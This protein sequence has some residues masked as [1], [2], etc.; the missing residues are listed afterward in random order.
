V[1]KAAYWEPIGDGRVRCGLCPQSCVIPEGGH[2]ICLGRV[3]RGGELQADSFGRCISIAMDPVEKKP[4]Y[5]VCPG[6]EILSVAPN[7]CNLRCDFCQNWTIAHE[8][9]RTSPLP[10]SELVRIATDAGSFGIAYTYTEPLVW[11]EYLLEAGALAREKGL[12]NVLVTNGVVNEAPLKELLPLV[13]AMNV[14]LK[15]MREEF[16]REYC[17][18]DGLDAVKRTIRLAAEACHVEI[19]NLVIPGLNDSEDEMRALVRFIADVDVRIPLHF[20]RYFPQH[21]MTLPATPLS[22]LG[23]AVDIAG[24]K[25]YYVYLGNVGHEERADTRCPVCDNLLVRR[26][27]Y[28]AALVGLAGHNC[29]RCGRAADIVWCA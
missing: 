2:G 19:T 11:F 16:Y 25:L 20:T 14:D 12:M 15:S 26:T 4:L 23:R 29:A 1:V 22:T 10:P 24:E 5:H 28:A 13:G 8:P 18:A 21:K 27:G 7:G 6:R 3:N 9:A 17:H